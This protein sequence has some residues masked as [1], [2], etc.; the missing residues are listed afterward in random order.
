MNAA[1]LVRE[2]LALNYDGRIKRL[3]A[4]GGKARTA[5]DAA[6]LLDRWERGDWQ[7]RQW[8]L[9]A[10][11]GSGDAD[12]PARLVDDPSRTVATYANVLLAALG[13][14]EQLTQTLLTLSGPRRKHLLRQLRRRDRLAPIDAFVAQLQAR[15]DPQAL[16]YRSLAS[17]PE[18]AGAD[19]ATLDPTSWQRRAAH[20][21]QETADRLVRALE[22]T[23]Q[24]H[25]LL[26]Q[27]ANAALRVLAVTHPDPALAV[28][29]ALAR[30]LPLN[31]IGLRPLLA[32]RPN[33]V[34][35]LVL[36]ST[37]PAALD[38]SS[39]VRRLDPARL[40][41]LLERQPGTLSSPT[42]WLRELT[43]N[44]RAVVFER[45]GAAWRDADD[46]VPAQLLALLP[47][48]LRLREARR[49]LA[50]PVLAT[51]PLALASYFTFLPWDEA[52]SRLQTWFQHPNAEMRAAA[53]RALIGTARF[54]STRLGELLALVRKRKHEQDPVR[55]AFLTALAELP[56]TRWTAD[57]LPDLA[58]VLREALDAT[59]L[60][61][62]ST[63]A[64]AR[65]LW[66]MLPH[67]PALT[68][69]QLAL[70]FRERGAVF[71]LPL[72]D[73]LNAADA[74]RVDDALASVCETWKETNR[75][76]WL[77]WVANCL[78]CRLRVCTRLLDAL[79]G[80]LDNKSLAWN[81][82]YLLRKHLPALEYDALLADRLR[83][84]RRWASV[85]LVF[86]HLYRR[87]Q[88][89]LTP[90]L[91]QPFLAGWHGKQD[92]IQFIP[93][94]GHQRLTAPQQQTLG[95]TL[96]S[97]TKL[98]RG[99][100][101]PRD[102][103]TVLLAIDRLARL[104]AADHQ[105]L[106]KL[107][108]EERPVIRDAAVRALGRFDAGEGLPVL[109]EAL[110]DDRARVAIYALR[111]GLAQ[112]PGDRVVEL[113][114][115][116]SL[117]KI[118]V[119]KEVVR[120][121]G[122][123]GSDAAVPWLEELAAQELHRDVRIALLRA[124]WDHLERPGVWPLLTAAAASPDGRL[125]NGVLRIPA[126]NLS[127]TARGRLLELLLGLT[128]HP[129][130]TVRV[131]VLQRFAVQPVPDPRHRLVERALTFLASPLPD[132]RTVA[133]Q[134]VL[135]VATTTDAEGI[136]AAVRALLPARKPLVEWLTAVTSA[137]A[138][139]PPRLAAVAGA[140]LTVLQ[141]DGLT[142]RWQPS[143]VLAAGG[144]SGLRTYLEQFVSRPGD[145][146]ADV[147][148]ALEQAL[149][150]CAG[151]PDR[152]E[153]ESL[154]AM[155]AGQVDERLR[156]LAVTALRVAARD[157]QGWTPARRARLE[158]YRADGSGVVAGEAQFVFPPEV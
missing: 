99:R 113:L 107:A 100:E 155:L 88:D 102:S 121:A 3:V 154:E 97:L 20:R 7:E 112:L 55:L 40:V 135:A 93:V 158:R 105:R 153:L 143:L 145:L 125:L 54:D 6:A 95:A 98:P 147:L 131:A 28:V 2:L 69:G 128:A 75:C 148:R 116:V 123:F 57:H 136:A 34:A 103:W 124:L 60:S 129:E 130:P 91:D 80:L 18:T 82:L 132:E 126:D 10:C 134:A 111:R 49:H 71:I 14:D 13:T 19:G 25:A 15:G 46:C 9:A 144:V 36:A 133:A 61:P 104:P 64:L 30:H 43:P 76:G 86:Q 8:A 51:R 149:E 12:R 17:L 139:N 24:P 33:E 92:L 87:R 115:G 58:G 109:V 157:G 89:L 5:P 35:D 31:Q 23:E 66:R 73:R 56:P 68:T 84:D 94:G 39:V 47:A 85:E 77:V 83:R 81:A 21:P 37:S 42:R 72:Q 11:W 122:E 59:D 118:T 117:E 22:A 48:E 4:L 29:R 53:W 140:T 45:C 62:A 38:F 108:S 127:E 114:R 65:L 110:D 146:H 70:L 63:Q 156:R 90:F 152:A 78:G 32:R 119:A 27:A 26:F 41:A 120:L 137:T 50:L 79:R 150:S 106:M 44:Q 67:Q 142:L 96:G 74:R 138:A 16:R 52:L 151:R 1:R 101:M 141:T